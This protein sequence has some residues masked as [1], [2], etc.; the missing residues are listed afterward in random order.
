MVTLPVT[1]PR[2]PRREGMLVLTA[3]T[4]HRKQSAG[5]L[6]YRC[7]ESGP[8]VLLVHPGGPYWARK[9]EHAWSMPKGEFAADEDAFA[10]A[11]REFEEETGFAPRGAATPLGVLKTSG[12]AIHAWA[13]EGDWEPLAL[14]SNSFAMEWPPRSGRTKTF[15]EVDRASWFDLTTARTK[16]HRGQLALIDRLEAL[17]ANESRARAPG[18]D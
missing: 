18:G 12:K 17:L 2:P 11:R 5:L 7:K 9:D 8:E 16:I 10:A 15:P 13:I 6:L 1:R 3:E 4:H 14:R